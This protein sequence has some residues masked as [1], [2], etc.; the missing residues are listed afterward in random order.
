[1]EAQYGVRGAEGGEKPFDTETRR[2]G[3][4]AGGGEGERGRGGVGAQSETVRE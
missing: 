4:R 2:Y 3:E 1:V